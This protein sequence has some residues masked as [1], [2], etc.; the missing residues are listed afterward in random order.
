[1]I[2]R[3]LVFL[4]LVLAVGLALPACTHG[5]QQPTHA[6]RLTRLEAERIALAN[7]PQMAESRL[8]T[9]EQAQQVRATR[10]AEAPQANIALDAVDAHPGSRIT[11]GGLN[12]PTIYN[13]ASA[14]ILVTQLITD[15]GRT[16]NLIRSAQSGAQATAAQERATSQEIVLAVDAAFYQALISQSVQQVAQQTVNQRQALV[17]QITVLTANKLRSDLD[18]SLARVQLAQAQLLLLDVQAQARDDMAGLN[19]LLGSEQN[20]TY[21]LDGSESDSP[22]PAPDDAE[23]LVSEAFAQR[24]DLAALNLYHTSAVQ[25]SKAERDL[26]M[27]AISAAGAAG[28]TP[29]RADQITS[30]W[31]GTA[32]AQVDIPI[33]NGALYS[34]RIHE[35]QLKAQI[36]QQQV[37]DLRDRIARDVRVSVLNTQT[38][39]QRISVTEAMLKE[40]NLALDLANA[41]YKLG[42]SGIVELSDAQLA[43]TQAA[44]ASV[45]ARYGYQTALA[46]LRFQLGR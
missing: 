27:P 29:V 25:F 32:G 43:Q 8:L 22:E 23:P 10:S 40:A 36:S 21:D 34:A 11:A 33:F 1:M 31:Y 45:N 7:N 15:F 13:R 18:L 2:E 16:R 39:Y 5:Q 30:S 26:W 4:G 14:G 3:K 41:R 28:T 24:P 38:A 44:I 35:A 20:T 19:T 37:R 12:N 46:G 9:L 17:D 42:L 6:T